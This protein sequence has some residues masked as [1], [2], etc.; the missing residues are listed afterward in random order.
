MM[1]RVPVDSQMQVWLPKV[2]PMIL[3]TVALNP[4]KLWTPLESKA[5]SEK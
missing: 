5:F 1:G 2:D 4:F 3:W